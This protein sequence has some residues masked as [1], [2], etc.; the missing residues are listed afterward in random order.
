MTTLLYN[1]VLS[2][3]LRVHLRQNTLRENAS[4]FFLLAHTLAKYERVGMFRR[5]MTTNWNHVDQLALNID[6]ETFQLARTWREYALSEKNVD[7][8]SRGVP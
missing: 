4:T 5:Q 7:T 3:K 6:D 8:F 2:L 1:D